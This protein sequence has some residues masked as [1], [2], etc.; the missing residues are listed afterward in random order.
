MSCRRTTTCGSAVVGAAASA[1]ATTG[2]QGFQ[3]AA[4]SQGFQGSQGPQGDSATFTDTAVVPFS[5]SFNVPDSTATTTYF[6]GSS[7]GLVVNATTDFNLVAFALPE[8]AIV[9]RVMYSVTTGSGLNGGGAPPGALLTLY[10]AAPPPVGSPAP[11]PTY[12]VIVDNDFA[13]AIGQ[14][15]RPAIGLPVAYAKG[16]LLAIGVTIYEPTV[17]PAL[18][19]LQGSIW[20]QMT[21]P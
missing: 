15:E 13:T 4:G 7:T 2:S 11:E 9:T 14:A 3:G 12:N 19:T 8:A 21:P 6:V 16:E 5:A 1:G 10:H 17:E 18:L 20:L